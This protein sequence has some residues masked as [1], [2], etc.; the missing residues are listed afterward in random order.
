MVRGPLTPEVVVISSEQV[1]TEQGNPPEAASDGEAGPDFLTPPRPLLHRRGSIEVVVNH[2]GEKSEVSGG[3]T[4]GVLGS[5]PEGV[6]PPGESGLPDSAYFDPWCDPENPKVI[7]F[8]DISAAAYMIRGGVV[9]TPCMM[10]NNIAI[11]PK[12]KQIFKVCRGLGAQ[13]FP[14][15][16]GV[17]ALRLN[18]LGNH[19]YPPPLNRLYY[20]CR[21]PPS[22]VSIAY[23]SSLC[24]LVRSNI[25]SLAGMDVYFK[26]DFLQF[27]GSFKERG[28]RNTLQL[29]SPKQREQGVVAASAGNHALALSYH[30]KS[31]GI[32]VTV[33]SS[34]ANYGAN[35]IVYGASLTEA[36]DFAMKKSK[37]LG[38]LYVNGYDHPHII[39]GQG[40]MGLEILEQVKGVDA[41]IIPVGGG[42]LIAGVALAIKSLSPNV[43]VIGCQAANAPGFATALKVGN[44]LKVDMKSTLA[45]G[46]AVATVG[47]NAFATAKN[48]IDK[49]VTVSDRPGGIAKL[50]S[51]LA[52]IGVSIKDIIHS[53]AWLMQDIFSCD[54]EVLA[55]TRDSEHAE[56][57]RQMLNAHYEQVS[58]VRHNP[59]AA[60]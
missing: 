6:S 49:M 57:L 19:L 17:G 26:K 54:V 5:K 21:T 35:V 20:P 53:R 24:Y 43:M 36:K 13:R 45:D 50:T 10:L 39:A 7:A 11:E 37:E 58:F 47:C 29:L 27:T 51:L 32:P 3:Y 16:A 31:L 56:E 40:T 30:G 46:L 59:T 8:Q 25:S 41:V 9:Y 52:G 42:G 55:E 23:T 14:A 15:V 18:D 2:G 12:V 34:C 33:V 4:D 28:A 44:P 48:L 60:I 1:D 22:S 38:A